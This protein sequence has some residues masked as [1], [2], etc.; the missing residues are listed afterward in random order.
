MARR[1]RAD[2]YFPKGGYREVMRRIRISLASRR[3]KLARS[4]L[5]DRGVSDRTIGEYYE[6]LC[7]EATHVKQA[8]G[9]ANQWWVS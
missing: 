7:R 5:Q 8:H 9:G 6:L 1:K 4:S 3:K 2:A